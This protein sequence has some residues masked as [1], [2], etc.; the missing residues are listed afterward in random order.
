[1]LTTF[2]LTATAAITGTVLL[3]LYLFSEFSKVSLVSSFNILFHLVFKTRIF[4]DLDAKGKLDFEISTPGLGR[5][6][7]L[8]SV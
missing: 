8:K 1:M 3:L 2:F 6:I 4:F 7:T 5:E